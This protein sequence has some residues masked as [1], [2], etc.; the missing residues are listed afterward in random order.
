[1][2]T[3]TILH[4]NDMHSAFIGMGQ[5]PDYSPFTRN[6]DKTRGLCAP[7]RLIANRRKAQKNRDRC[8]CSTRAIT[9]LPAP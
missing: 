7:G 8:W 3:F 5:A 1:M 6:D 9:A 4:T 2:R